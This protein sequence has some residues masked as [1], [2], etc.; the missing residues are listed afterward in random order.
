MNQLNKFLGENDDFLDDEDD[1]GFL[2]LENVKE[3]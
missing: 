3:Q 2:K 1:E